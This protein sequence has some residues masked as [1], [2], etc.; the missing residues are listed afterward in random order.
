MIA[1][2]IAGGRERL[3][4]FGDYGGNG[5]GGAVREN[6]ASVHVFDCVRNSYLLLI[7][8]TMNHVG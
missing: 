2:N 3:V 1:L 5:G 7:T 4:S 8:L 6:S